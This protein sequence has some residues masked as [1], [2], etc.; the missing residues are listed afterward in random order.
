[1]RDAI[2]G[3]LGDDPK[4]VDAAAIAFSD[5]NIRANFRRALESGHSAQLGSSVRKD[6]PEVTVRITSI[7]GLPVHA[8]RTAHLAVTSS[9]SDG[10]GS[11]GDRQA[12]V[13]ESEQRTHRSGDTSRDAGEYEP[14]LALVTPF[15]AVV[16]KIAG[17]VNQ[18]Q[19]VVGVSASTEE[20]TTVSEPPGWQISDM[21]QVAYQV[22]VRWPERRSPFARARVHPSRDVVLAVRT[23]W[24]ME[25]PGSLGQIAP[26]SPRR[27]IEH[28]AF[29]G[30][31]ELQRTV[32]N[33]LGRRAVSDGTNGF[34]PWL[35]SLSYRAGD[36]FAGRAV[37]GRFRFQGMRQDTEILLAIADPGISA[38]A[39]TVPDAVIE[40]SVKTVAAQAMTRSQ[41]RAWGGQLRIMGG[42]AMGGAGPAASYV[43][44][45]RSVSEVRDVDELTAVTTYRG[46]L[47]RVRTDIRF[48]V[49]AA[50]PQTTGAT[51]TRWAEGGRTGTE[52]AGATVTVKGAATVWTRPAE[53]QSARPQVSWPSP[54][55]AESPPQAPAFADVLA[56]AGDAG[57][58]RAQA[59]RILSRTGA[60]C[61]FPAEA[62]E[63]LVG[64]VVHRL[65]SRRMIDAVDVAHVADELRV[66]LRAHAHEIAI[67]ADGVRF[68]L[69]S[70]HPGSGYPDVFLRG[71][72]RA[73]HDAYR[74]AVQGLDTAETLASQHS[75]S[76]SRS[77]GVEKQ[78]GLAFYTFS[79]PL[80]VSGEIFHT[81][82]R[83][84]SAENAEILGVKRSLTAKPHHWRY[85]M[86]VAVS[87]GGT[88]GRP[89]APLPW[90]GH[91]PVG[92]DAGSLSVQIDV[93]A[94]LPPGTDLSGL[95]DTLTP[96]RDPATWSR[97][98]PPAHPRT[99]HLPADYEIERIN[100]VPHMLSTLA[101]MLAELG[102]DTR[103]TRVREMVTTPLL[104]RKPR[105]FDEH[106]PSLRAMET[107]ASWPVR[108]SRFERS[109]IWK[110]TLSLNLPNT[111][112]LL[113]S[114]MRA[115][116]VELSTT[117]ANPSILAR[118]D[119]H[120]FTSDRSAS[121]A[122]R[123]DDTVGRGVT[124]K[125]QASMAARPAAA[126]TLA[127]T[128]EASGKR[129][130]R[131]GANTRH[132][133][134]T[135]A[136]TQF[137]TRGYLVAFDVTHRLSARTHDH[138]TDCTGM[139]HQTE[140]AART[141]WARTA[142]AVAVWVPAAEI[143]RIGA[144]DT[145]SL[146]R[147][148]PEDAQRCSSAS[149]HSDPSTARAA[150]AAP[151]PFFSSLTG[152]LPSDVELHDLG[153]IRAFMHAVV[154]RLPAG[155]DLLRAD[156]RWTHGPWQSRRI[157]DLERLNERL[158]EDL[159]GPIA[160]VF[161]FGPALHDMLNGGWPLHLEGHTA[162][163]KVEQLVV[164]HA[165]LGAGSPLA[166][167]LARTRRHR[168]HEWSDGTHVERE[169]RAALFAGGAM[170]SGQRLLN[171]PGLLAAQLNRNAKVSTAWTVS[172]RRSMEAETTTPRTWTVH[173]LR[174]RLEIH[175]YIRPGSYSAGPLRLLSQLVDHRTFRGVP[176]LGPGQTRQVGSTSTDS[177]TLYGA[178][179]S[180]GAET[181]APSGSPALVAGPTTA[182]G[183]PGESGQQ[184]GSTLRANSEPRLLVRHIPAPGLA[185]RI[186][187][188][189]HPRT[190][191][192]SSTPVR[193]GL[194]PRS[195]YE[196][197]SATRG[198]R[199][200][201]H[202]ERAMSEKGYVVKLDD[203]PLQQI[204]LTVDVRHLQIIGA[205]PGR[206]RVTH[207]L[208][209]SA[210]FTAT[211]GYQLAALTETGIRGPG[212]AEAPPRSGATL[213][214][215]S[216]HLA[217]GRGTASTA[218]VTTKDPLTA[219]PDSADED[220]RYL[221]RVTPRW[222]V[223]PTYRGSVI[224][225]A[226]S[227]PLTADDLP[228]LIE[229]DGQGLQQLGVSASWNGDTS[230]SLA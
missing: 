73:S 194:H 177:F 163:G 55:T 200:A 28:A 36:L 37:R 153:A 188:L 171:V 81:W 150:P 229:V 38:E 50:H 141:R 147:L 68:P 172:H 18:R 152:N 206:L 173:D 32:E 47:E 201:E 114:R 87:I 62:V 85:E 125:A 58:R 110:D 56:D 104:G 45:T 77:K 165:E 92:P 57:R 103:S 108:R 44:S 93:H 146:G 79:P 223:T 169:S 204:R 191:G 35:E 49:W 21:R 205:L 70:L 88:W 76:A 185:A 137:T 174:I 226:W 34:G 20:T 96:A 161:R 23:R 98:E 112:G 124:A 222:H 145:T 178:V 213:K 139:Q 209:R 176:V 136:A 220:R 90:P 212:I 2:A 219:Q 121:H 197:M 182:T 187:E 67:S 129:S 71:A 30:L 59:R 1:M 31:G 118:D 40:H 203:A 132:M 89:A 14:A 109:V 54:D 198:L 63:R 101:G 217:H 51:R 128:A 127:G 4:L 48:V 111:G 22:T 151:E 214:A 116:L 175:P 134:T 52:A 9:S 192:T 131:E 135:G 140:P 149:G 5:E 202:M 179:R 119:E 42:N 6:A 86:D 65:H 94:P 78:A 97:L 60:Q 24:Q 196:L 72:V 138:W 227:A 10:S 126:V 228:I 64:P 156:I 27:T 184:G 183:L 95:A 29:T 218:S 117:L 15:G 13:G 43:T 195:A 199:L 11:E 74:G 208:T 100:P 133:S 130:R 190:D 193:P 41:T 224:P 102:L 157:R 225:H 84:H 105:G 115:A 66:F 159:M 8:Q 189:A 123:T 80:S 162:F 170:A 33:M 210:K 142:D 155:A 69:S 181:E 167:V 216:P 168:A 154:Q 53:A 164:V 186:R 91:T 12:A 26:A 83:S 158:V 39:F 180:A 99:G 3:L 215:V 160:G 207:A 7:D 106:S 221:V 75:H 61:R 107:F 113:G 211:N 230:E 46:P 120:T 122:T 16:A 19:T 82:S 166:P 148:A 143:H 144:L 17:M 25:K